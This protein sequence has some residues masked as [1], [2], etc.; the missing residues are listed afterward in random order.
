MKVNRFKVFWI[1]LLA[2]TMAIAAGCGGPAKEQPEVASDPEAP[3]VLSELTYWVQIVSQVSATMKS[4]NEIEAY[5]ELERIT[6]VKVDFQHPPQGQ[7]ATEQF[8][9]MMTSDKLP[10]VIEY[11]WAG[12]PGPEKAIKD[13]KI[14]KLNDL[15]D[16]YAPNFKKG[17]RG[18]SG[19]KKEITTDDGKDLRVP[20]SAH[21]R[22]A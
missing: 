8:N 12:Y 9:L 10:D 20:V 22:Q 4:Y 16:Q 13:G 21:R 17:A 14:I 18:A 5:K 3:P 2:V 7:Q 11:S 15:I 19:G 1:V 6:G